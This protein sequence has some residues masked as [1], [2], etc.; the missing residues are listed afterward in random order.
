MGSGCI[1]RQKVKSQQK[2]TVNA[3]DQI[4]RLAQESCAMAQ[5]PE[6]A[7]PLHR[8]AAPWR[9]DLMK[10]R[11]LRVFDPKITYSPKITYLNL[12]TSK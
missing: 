6:E 11:F 4:L 10:N 1:N 9:R 2:S 5:G 3:V 8:K 7:A 12:T